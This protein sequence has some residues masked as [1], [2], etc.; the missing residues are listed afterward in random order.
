MYQRYLQYKR[1]HHRP[2]L[3]ARWKQAFVSRCMQHRLMI[4]RQFATSRSVPVLLAWT[5]YV[6]AIGVLLLPMLL[7]VAV[8][9]TVARAFS[10]L[11]ARLA[12]WSGLARNLVRLQ[13][14][15]TQPK[16]EALVLRLYRF[17]EQHETDAL[18]K[19]INRLTHVEAWYSPTAFLAVLQQ[20]QGSACDVRAGRRPEGLSRRIFK[21][22]RRSLPGKLQDGGRGHRRKQTLHHLQQRHEVEYAGRSVWR[23]SRRRR[24][25]AAR[26]E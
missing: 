3:L 7:G 25:R 23:G 4:E 26:G 8:L 2:S 13:A 19:T 21:C 1:L 6:A 5:I 11:L 22:W 12:G 18:I 16:E 9:R 20:N 24:C 15:A 10:G 14:L 17:M